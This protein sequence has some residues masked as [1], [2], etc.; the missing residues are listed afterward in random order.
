M[1]LSFVSTGTSPQTRFISEFQDH[2]RSAL[3]R[4]D[5]VSYESDVCTDDA[6]IPK[7]STVVVHQQFL[8]VT[9]TLPYFTYRVEVDTTK[10]RLCL[11]A[12]G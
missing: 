7:G 4:A 9:Q 3:F 12:L 10:S 8:H 5:I 1:S 11:D 6:G 2:K